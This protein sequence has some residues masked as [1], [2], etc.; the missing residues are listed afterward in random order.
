MGGMEGAAEPLVLVDD[1]V[2]GVR[3]LTLNRPRKRN[4]LSHGLRT[5]LFEALREGDAVVGPVIR[6]RRLVLL[7][8]LRPG[9]GSLRRPPGR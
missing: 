2:E 3:R 6:G 8:R 1:P 5:Q 7:G 9:P 4:A